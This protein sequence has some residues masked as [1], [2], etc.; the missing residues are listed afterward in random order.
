MELKYKSAISG[1]FEIPTD[2]ARRLLPA[3]LEPV[4]LH[5][6]SSILSMSV[7]DVPESLLG[8]HRQVIM[9]VVV[10]PLIKDPEA[11]IPRAAVYPYI[12]GSTTAPV[13]QLASE[14]LHLPHFPEDV[15]IDLVPGERSMT[16]KIAAGG[17]PVAELT[18]TEYSWE[19]A[20]YL[21][22]CFT[23]DAS[24][25]YLASVRMKCELSEHEDEVGK[26]L[27]HDHPFHAGLAVGD[28]YDVPFREVW[29]RDGSQTFESLDP[30]RDT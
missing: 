20:S 17:E 25:A 9:S 18:V 5:H 23:K 14:M 21:Y 7:F 3:H 6:G 15:Q 30:L 29:M 10:A 8:P 28:V 24:G 19:P 2:N 26:L 27:L 13:R 12:V 11:P 4:E 22:Q 1:Y 16:A